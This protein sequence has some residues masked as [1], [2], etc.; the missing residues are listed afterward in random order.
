M[1]FS[2]LDINLQVDPSAPARTFIAAVRLAG[3]NDERKGKNDGG[4]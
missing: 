2:R 3:Y 4:I 1:L